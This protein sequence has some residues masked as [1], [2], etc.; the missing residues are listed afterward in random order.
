MVISGT[1]LYAQPSGN[2][3][4][5]LRDKLDIMLS[6]EPLSGASV[7]FCAISADGRELA[8]YNTG[9]NMIPASNMKLVTTAIAM[10]SLGSDF[11]FETKI[12]Y[13]GTVGDDGVLDGNLYIIG[14]GDPTLASSDSIAFPLEEIFAEWKSF[15]DERGIRKIDGFVIGDGRYFQGMREEESWL[16][17][18]IGTYYGTGVSGLQFYENVKDFKVS[19]GEKAGDS[20]SIVQAYP[21]TPW[22]RYRYDCSTGKPG[23]GDELYMYTSDLSPV[24]EIRGTFAAGKAAKTIRCSNKFPEYTCAYYFTEYLS[25][26]GLACSGGPADI[27]GLSGMEPEAELE[28]IGSTYSPELSRIVY[29]TNHASN[30]LFAETLFRTIGREYSGDGSYDASSAACSSIIRELMPESPCGYPRIKD[31]SGLSRQNYVSPMFLCR[32]LEA[33]MDSPAFGDF[34]ATLPHPGSGGTLSFVMKNS[35]ESVKRRLCVKSGSMDGVRCYS[36]YV[37]PSEG[38][39]EKTIIFS[40]MVNNCDAPSWKVQQLLDSLMASVASMN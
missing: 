6:S 26:K 28:I 22:M 25:S 33:M 20:I 23:T 37:I 18:D 2:S 17:A 39:K 31:G 11:R 10:H 21:S 19:P 27:G 38:T 5:V 16:W 30:N 32:F 36:G 3:T 29:E 7:G 34:V 8:G 40:I 12:G 1:V 35:P 15:L 24:A 9:R 13:S 14:G 4:D